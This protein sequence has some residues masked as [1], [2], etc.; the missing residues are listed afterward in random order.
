MK[1]WIM[2]RIFY[3]KWVWLGDEIVRKEDIRRLKLNQSDPMVIRWEI[4]GVNGELITAFNFDV[5]DGAGEDELF[6][7]VLR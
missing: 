7:K 3:R 4:Y 6:R 2:N 1:R 5:D